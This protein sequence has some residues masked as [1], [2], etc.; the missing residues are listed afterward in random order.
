M[1]GWHHLLNGHVFR[2]VREL[3]KDREAWRAAA[4]GGVTKNLTQLGD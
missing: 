4:R 1:V 3:E 2:Q